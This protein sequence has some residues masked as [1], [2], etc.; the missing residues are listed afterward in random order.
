MIQ[1]LKV[2][3]VQINAGA[4]KDSNINKVSNFINEAAKQDVQLIALPEVFNFRSKEH[5]QSLNAAEEIKDSESIKKISELAQKLQ[6]NI[7]I[8]SMMIKPKQGL[9]FNT[10]LLIDSKGNIISEYQ[11]IHLFDIKYGNQEILE[12]SRNQSG[13]KPVIA[14]LSIGKEEIKIGMSVCYDLRFPELYRNYAKEKVEI[15][16]VPSAFTQ[17]TGEAHW[18]TLV[19]ARAIENQCFVL[20][21]NQCGDGGQVKTY[22][23]SLI[24]GPWGEILAEAS[25]DK[26]ELIYADLDFNQLR[27]IRSRLPSLEHRKL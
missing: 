21:P 12:S 10:S 4:D 1:S 11:K 6:I 23:H 14:K 18:H 9:P 5:G 19:R 3:L 16:T 22:G 7:L 20:A 2:A 26:E 24:V 15:I 27:D 13:S 25:G 17:V 8:G